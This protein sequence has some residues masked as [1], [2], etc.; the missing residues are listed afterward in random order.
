MAV[1]DP[2][3]DAFKDENG[4]VAFDLDLATGASKQAIVS[5]KR[6]DDKSFT[7]FGSDYSDPWLTTPEER[8]AWGRQKLAELV[9]RP[10]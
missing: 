1:T 5:A 9:D 10:G 2:E 3:M 4:S 7:Y 8:E 6:L